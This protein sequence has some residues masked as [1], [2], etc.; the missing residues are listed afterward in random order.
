MN[1]F[2]LDGQ[3][4]SYCTAGHNAAH[5]N[6]RTVEVPIGQRFI[7]QN[8]GCRI[9]EVGDVLS[10]Y[11]PTDHLVVDLGC[12]RDESERLLRVDIVDFKDD[13]G[14]D[15]IVS[16]STM[17]HVGEKMSSAGKSKIVL[18]FDNLK[19]LLRPGGT[20][21]VTMPLG[22]RKGLDEMLLSGDLEFTKHLRMQCQ[23]KDNTWEE[24][25]WPDH[26]N[27]AGYGKFRPGAAA[28]VFIGIYDWHWRL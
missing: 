28:D 4:Y 20:M 2:S 7:A 8:K 26:N 13:K 9:L 21:L 25:P 10:N 24:R 12:K 11:G 27:F 23:G 1:G 3:G 6:E 5:R 14:F 22:Y 16:I 18:A 17:E 15:A 19:S